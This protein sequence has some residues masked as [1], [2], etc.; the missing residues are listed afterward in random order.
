LPENTF[1]TNQAD[2]QL[3]PRLNTLISCS[4]ELKF[5]VGFFYFSGIAQLYKSLKQNPDVILKV[6]VGLNVDRLNYEL[7]EFS[8]H[9]SRKDDF[10]LLHHYLDSVV[11]AINNDEF[12]TKEFYEQAE[13][14]IQA[15]LEERLIIRKTRE[16]N[17][18]K[19]YFF[20]MNE[21]S[22]KVKPA[23]FITGSSNLTRAGLAGQGELNVEISDYG[24]VEA[25]KYFDDLWLSAVQV[26]ERAEFRT[27]LIDTIKTRTIY[28]KPTPYEVYAYVL[29]T[30][31]DL[32]T[33]VDIK[34]H[35]LQL[36][37]NAGFK[38]YRYQTDAVAQALRI[39]EQQNG[40]II[41]DVV[42]LGKSIIAGMVARQLD[43][44]GI[45][46]CPPGLIGG[47]D[48][49]GN[50]TGWEKYKRD[51]EIDSWAVESSGN[52]DKI[53]NMVQKNSS[54]D[55]VIIDEAHRFRNQDTK[56]YQTLCNICR[57]KKVILLTATPF[58]NTPADIFSMLKLFITPGKS[59]LSLTGDLEAE[60]RHYTNTFRRLSNIKKYYN[61]PDR[62]KRNETKR[63]YQV[64]FGEENIDLAKVNER[65]GY[66]ASSIKQRIAPVTIRRNRIDLTSDPVYS[67]EII[68]LPKVQDPHE[69]FFELT[70]EQSEFYD[71]VIHEYFGEDGHFSGAIY[72]PFIYEKG[73]A[74]ENGEIDEETNRQIMV[75]KNLYDFMRRLLVKR[76]ESSFGA[77]HSSIIS[78]RYVTEQVLRFIDKTGGKYILDR[79]LL[80]RLNQEP[81][82]DEISRILEE[83][84][85]TLDP[86]VVPKNERVYE[87][88]TFADKEKFISSIKADLELFNSIL[89]EL[90]ALKLVENDPKVRKL[91]E[92]LKQVVSRH[93]H[94][95]EPKR[96]VVVFSEY[97][98]T[99]NHIESYLNTRPEFKGRIL[100]VKGYLPKTHNIEVLA[101][102]D[103]GYQDKSD[104]YDILISS[105]KMSEGFNLNRA[106]AVINYDIPWN[107]TRVIQRVGRI[108]R[109]SR[110]VFENLYIYNFFPTVQGSTIVKSREIASQKMF[111]IHNTLGEDTKI[112]DADEEPTASS[113]YSRLQR[114][115]DELEEES[116]Q[117]TIRR[118]YEAIDKAT[119]DKIKDLPTRLKAAKNYSQNEL[120]VFFKRASSLFVKTKS[121]DGAPQEITFAGALPHIECSANEPSLELGS[122]FWADYQD[123]KNIKDKTAFAVNAV[124]LENKAFNKLQAVRNTQNEAYQPF[125]YFICDLLEDITDYKTLPDFTLRR[126]ANLKPDDAKQVSA[127]LKALRKEL[128][129][130]YLENIRKRTQLT[131]REVIVAVENR[132]KEA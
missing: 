3:K 48:N 67:R 62:K 114:N 108:N 129:D 55:T 84:A 42:G 26:T 60:F 32:Q 61:S 39:L 21:V 56:D 92:E 41:S 128:G 58:N 105:D 8:G 72:Q 119:K 122:S 22:C 33:G 98:D 90:D 54:Y 113:L 5:L 13:F 25:E 81:D 7:I 97:V 116:F 104:D 6:L 36:L 64:L 100:S 96:K 23:I 82:E 16:P 52:L 99:V 53:F 11:K 89:E 51:F 57:G 85:K 38:E 107:P 83:Y 95:L 94:S 45:I 71:R 73:L 131:S 10:T 110:K 88:D 40:V 91:A 125:Q 77:F 115:P 66:L 65:T 30:Y 44:K 123:I 101:N 24:T 2:K 124:S 49:N 4:S 75:Q 117:T 102:F 103:A 29:K 76:F 14:F 87:V 70:P 120:L 111:L 27:R 19:L 50:Y 80:L 79:K 15:I 69:S 17:H 28:N 127:E 1:I 37:I 121:G 43:T 132:S 35:I 130:N 20:K 112:F 12:D 9:N 106:G 59:S 47:V 63:D 18:S 74:A 78:F 126:L 31:L 118:K 68:D 93:N 34:E 46:I 109:I 86:E